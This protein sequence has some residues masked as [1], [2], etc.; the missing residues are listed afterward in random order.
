MMMIATRVNT[1]INREKIPIAAS[2]L[3]KRIGKR[4][5]KIIIEYKC[6]LPQSAA[7]K[8]LHMSWSDYVP[9]NIT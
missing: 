3:R 4:I 9:R 5:S 7:L 1:K 6:W 2:R 8:V